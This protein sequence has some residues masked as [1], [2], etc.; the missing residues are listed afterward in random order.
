MPATC[1]GY[2]QP[3]SACDSPGRQCTRWRKARWRGTGRSSTASDSSSNSDRVLSC[4]IDR[5]RTCSHEPP[6][7]CRDDDARVCFH[8]PDAATHGDARVFST[9][10]CQ[11]WQ[12]RHGLSA[13]PSPRRRERYQPCR[14]VMLPGGAPKPSVRRADSIRSCR[15]AATRPPANS[16]RPSAMAALF[17]RPSGRP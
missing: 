17:A 6:T 16:S 7:G 12:Q 9:R 10:L 13:G 14:L 8:Q 2:L 3:E 11:R 15:R 1:A 4:L 5:A